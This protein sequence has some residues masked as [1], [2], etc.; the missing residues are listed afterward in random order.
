MIDAYN[1]RFNDR[2]KSCKVGFKVR[3]NFDHVLIRGGYNELVGAKKTSAHE[4]TEIFPVV[5]G[6]KT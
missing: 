6:R 2:S 3:F 4:G 1:S 5:D